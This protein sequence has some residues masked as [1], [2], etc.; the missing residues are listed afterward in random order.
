MKKNQL[1]FE[2]LGTQFVIQ[3]EE[4]LEYLE[5]ISRYLIKKVNDVN[6]NTTIGEPFK[7]A[8]LAGLNIVD[9]L[10]KARNGKKPAEPDEESNVDIDEITLRMINKIDKNL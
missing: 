3:S 2:L 8:I 7:L 10:F 4:E 9:E 6:H 5:R 1:K